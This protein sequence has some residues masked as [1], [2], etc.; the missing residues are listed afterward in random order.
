MNCLVY[1]PS[2]NSRIKYVCKQVF[3]YWLG[4]EVNLTTNLNL[5]KNY[6]GVKINYG[7]QK[8]MS[9]E[10]FL[11]RSN[12]L[13]D[14]KI[15]KLRFPVLFYY[16]IPALFHLN[17]SDGEF[18]FDILANIFFHLSRYEEYLPFKADEHSR[19]P[20]NQSWAHQ[21]NSLQIPIA[22]LL[23]NLLKEA[24]IRKFPTLSFKKRAFHFLP[25]YD[26]DMAWAFRHK[27]WKRVIGGY[28]NDLL[29]GQ[30]TSLKSRLRTHAGLQKDP[31]QTFDL[32]EKWTEKYQLKPIYFF[33]LGDYGFYDKNNTIHSKAFKNLILNIAQQ[34]EI[35]I[36][37]SYQSIDN[38]LIIKKEVS[39]LAFIAKQPICRSRQHFLKVHLPTTYRQLL[40][41]GIKADYSM[42]YASDT[43]FRA[44]T[45]L[46]FYWYD[47]EKETMTDL[48]IHPF[49]VMDV[50]LKQYL[51]LSPEVA[52]KR[53]KKLVEAVKFVDG[54]F[55]S[56][57]HNSSFSEL[58]D[59]SEWQ[60]VYEY[61]LEVAK[62]QAQ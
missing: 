18:P 35:G 38:Q 58:E 5:Y 19:F 48:L 16:K 45:A 20:A 61:L 60:E 13:L 36:H 12:F 15:Q 17:T 27:G 8:I 23:T 47:L 40:A 46:P 30:W 54:I 32:L 7:E 55:C 42:G 25:T 22:D 28:G 52:K 51:Q 10:L 44:G 29:K 41:T 14:L 6:E 1:S 31:F 56:L 43:G 39:R 49:Q 11:P 50:T 26:I 57:W 62:K 53:I 3:E 9:Q 4:L 21:Q 34:R 59:W 2:L 33:L 24:I 37:P